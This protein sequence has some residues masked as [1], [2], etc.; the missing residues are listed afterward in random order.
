MK[1]FK[2]LKFLL[3]YGSYNPKVIEGIDCQT[4]RNIQLGRDSLFLKKDADVI[5]WEM[6]MQI[7]LTKH[8]NGRYLNDK[9]MARTA[10]QAAIRATTILYGDKYYKLLMDQAQKLWDKEK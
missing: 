1:N 3:K 2:K 8:E 9:I 7:T 5:V 10:L 6:H 4:W